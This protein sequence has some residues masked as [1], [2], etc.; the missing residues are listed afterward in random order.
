MLRFC[1]VGA[2]SAV[3][4]FSVLTVF[5]DF[6]SFLLSFS[7]TAAYVFSVLVHFIGNKYFTFRSTT[8]AYVGEGGRYIG[9]VMVNYIVTL[10]VVWFVVVVFNG[11]AHVATVLSIAATVGIGFA[12]SK[13]WVFR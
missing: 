9:V 5:L 13:Y 11:T 4:Q 8:D 7:V 12:L 2:V 1:F 3:A 6:F 10:G